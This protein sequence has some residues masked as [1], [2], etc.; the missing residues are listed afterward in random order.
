MTRRQAKGIRC[1]RSFRQ[2]RLSRRALEAF[3]DHSHS[4]SEIEIDPIIS[5]F[6]KRKTQSPDDEDQKRPLCLLLYTSISLALAMDYNTTGIPLNEPEFLPNGILVTG[7]EPIR[8]HVA[9]WVVLITIN[10]PTD[11]PELRQKLDKDSEL[12]S[13]T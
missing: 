5:H 7:G 12:L 11:I 8:N 4:D 9:T 10:Q 13:L 1:R 6:R 2:R 3:R